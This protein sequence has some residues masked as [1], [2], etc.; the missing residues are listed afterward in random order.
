MVGQSAY[1]S[2]YLHGNNVRMS[3][4]SSLSFIWLSSVQV[5]LTAYPLV[6]PVITCD[7]NRD[8]LAVSLS[9]G[10]F[11]GYKVHGIFPDALQ[12]LICFL[13]LTEHQIKSTW[14]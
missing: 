12:V 9:Y 1:M 11:W 6:M 10:N 8:S 4:A 3:R 7:L 14:G 2:I 13:L 5:E